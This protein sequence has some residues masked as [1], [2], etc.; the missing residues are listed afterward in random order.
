ME[1][2]EVK[3]KESSPQPVNA[4]TSPGPAAKRK[5]W[6][7]KFRRRSGEDLH[8]EKKVRGGGWRW[9]VENGPLNA[10]LVGLADILHLGNCFLHLRCY[11]RYASVCGHDN[12][13]LE[14][15]LSDALRTN[16]WYCELL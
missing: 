4:P 5:S 16:E 15:C 13:M 11:T 8:Q 6:A 14:W 3:A 10:V 9:W 7:S 12:I 1:R 2:A